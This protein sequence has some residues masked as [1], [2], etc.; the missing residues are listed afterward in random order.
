[1]NQT[2]K[3][4]LIAIRYLFPIV[5]LALSLVLACVPCYS[6]TTADTGAQSAISLLELMD[7][8]RVEVCKYL[9]ETTGTRDAAV[10]T[11]SRTVLALLVAV[12]LLYALALASAVY[13]FVSARRYFQNPEDR[14]SARILFIT[15]IPN[16]TVGFL[17]QALCFPLMA[18]PHIMILLYEKILHYPV[19]LSLTFVDPL[20]LT[21]ILYAISVVLS[22]VSASRETALS[23]NPFT[24]P[25]ATSA[26]DTDEE[27]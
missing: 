4:K 6:Y 14:G 8:A 12:S 21:V 27:E 11:F 10:I 16:R 1:M 3:P 15:L 17:L 13:I 5:A 7:N 2:S 18:L 19:T 23:L 22:I 20:I 25:R 9:F 24:R 26:N